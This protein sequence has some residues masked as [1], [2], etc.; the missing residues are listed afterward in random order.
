[1]KEMNN[2]VFFP[3]FLECV[4]NAPESERADIVYCIVQ[5]GIYGRVPK[6]T[7]QSFKMIFPAIKPIIDASVKRYNSQVENGKKGGRP[8]KI[9]TQMKP[10]QNPKKTQLKPKANRTQTQMK[11][12]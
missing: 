8:K 9:K 6:K 1:M 2:F 12:K 7:T 10:K 3:S 4:N 11:P 5:Y